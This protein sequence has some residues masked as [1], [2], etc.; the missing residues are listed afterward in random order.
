M[1]PEPLQI[2]VA[3]ADVLSQPAE[4]VREEELHYFQRL[5]EKMLQ[6][7][8]QAN[9]I[10]LAAPQVGIS[11]RILVM[12]VGEPLVM[13]NPEILDRQGHTAITEGC[14]SLPGQARE[15][16]RAFKVRV[17]YRNLAWRE[18]VQNLTDLASVCCQHEI[19]HLDGILMTD[20]QTVTEAL[21]AQLE[22][23]NI[24]TRSTHQLLAELRENMAGGQK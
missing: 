6:T 17:R 7:M 8:R 21:I 1:D 23:P 16:L 13:I 15:V 12:G 20:R 19:D 5:G 3:P 11:R 22:N 18:V 24:S 10:G 2:V 4:E 14:L 9:G